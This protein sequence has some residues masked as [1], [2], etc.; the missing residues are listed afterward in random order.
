MTVH[1]AKGL[2]FSRV[3]LPFLDWQPLQGE[4]QIPPLLIGGDSRPSGQG[5]AWPVP[6][7][8]KNKIPCTC[9]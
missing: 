7:S 9:C 3:F 8:R 2:E 6:I 5:L 1:G 4:D